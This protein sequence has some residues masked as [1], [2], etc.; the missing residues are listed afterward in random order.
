MATDSAPAAPPRRM[1][2]QLPVFA[3]GVAAAVL[4]WRY[5]PP[6]TLAGHEQ[7][8]RDRYS[9]RQAIS[10]RPVNVG[11]VQSLLNSLGDASTRS[12]GNADVAFVQGSAY[13]LLAEQGPPD[14]ATDNWHRA[15][16]LFA[17]CD[18]A[19]LTDKGDRGRVAFRA[20]K[21][22]AG[23]GEGDPTTLVQALDTVPGGEE[24]GERSRLLAE[25]CLRLTPPNVKRAKTLL[26]EH[27]SGPP[28]GTPEQAA[29]LK[30]RLADLYAATGEPNAARQWLKDFA[31]PLPTALQ[32]DAKLRLARLALADNDVNE[33]VKQFQAAEALPNLGV[34]QLAVV[35][36]EM[37]R[38]LL[39][40]GNPVAGRD[41]LQRAAESNTPVGQAAEVRLAELSTRDLDPSGGVAH[42]EVALKGVKTAADWTNEYT[43]LADLR[44]ACEAVILTCQTTGKCAAAVRAAEVYAAV[45]EGG[46]DRELWADAMTTWAGLPGTTDPADK[47]K[48]AADEFVRLAET[49]PAAAKAAFLQRA[50]AA[51]QSAGDT[52]AA[53]AV[54][55]KVSALPEATGDV[56]AA[57]DLQQAVALIARGE[58][59]GG[60]KLLSEVAN[61]AG[62]VGTKA[63][64]QLALVQAAE[65]KKQLA[66]KAGDEAGRKKV[67]HAADLLTQLANKTYTTADEQVCHQQALYELGKLQ[68]GNAV[69]SVH[70]V[71]DAEMR[72]RRL[73]GEYPTG[74]YADR[75]RMYLGIALSLLAQGAASQGVPP[76]DAAKKF[77]EA[78]ALFESLGKAADEFVR[79]Q[80]DIRL[81]HTL[82]HMKEYEVATETGTAL[83]DKYRGKVEELILLNIVYS[84]HTQSRRADRAK[85]ALER[86]QKAYTALPDAAYSNNMLEYTK[87]YWTKQLD[88]LSEK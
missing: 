48:K 76:A 81:V 30:L 52:Q 75:G 66:V 42:L 82:L 16:A 21:A 56:K 20:A 35:R 11:E 8:E 37:G 33:A 49:R 58:I 40:L 83:A 62:P 41:Y 70:N 86:M 4:A 44:A 3:V 61:T 57:V 34:A 12:G 38:G 69:P 85:L 5:F 73:A 26:A 63:T 22:A 74:E 71:S 54:L 32:A 15:H 59:D 80:A 88:R 67:E 29:R 47:Y 2:W 27:L 23:A 39:Q 77:A 9:L 43:K 78:K 6:P 72:F 60:V 64:L 46:K 18:P 24:A 84:A 53:T 65:G 28:R 1:Y 36:Y 19:K 87:G 13:L 14:Q 10:R 51:Y 25:A 55:A 7:V 79:S 31:D 45:A 17:E 68:L 50:A